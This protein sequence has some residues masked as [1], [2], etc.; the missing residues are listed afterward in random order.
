MRPARA[1]LQQFQLK[2]GRT[3]VSRRGFT[4]TWV[5]G[6]AVMSWTA[7]S[8]D[9]AVE[10]ATTN[11]VLEA[12]TAPGLTVIATVNLG[13]S[14]ASA[15][16]FRRAPRRR[17]GAQ[18]AGG[19]TRELDRQPHWNAPAGSSFGGYIIET[20]SAPRISDLAQVQVG[21]AM[22]FSAPV[23]VGNCNLRVQALSGRGPG[24]PS[25]EV[26]VR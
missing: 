3:L 15:H 21:T 13:R 6:I 18:H 10:E 14:R 20:G 26:L 12:G 25:N 17:R 9:G 4:V 2:V 7:T 16:R 11:H 8:A 22:T 19:L 23:P 1:A 24:L 5:G